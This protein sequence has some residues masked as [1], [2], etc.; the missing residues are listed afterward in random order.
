MHC[1]DHTHLPSLDLRKGEGV[2]MCPIQNSTVLLGSHEL[3]MS[4]MTTFWK[5]P[6][7][8][9]VKINSPL[10]YKHAKALSL[11]SRRS[12]DPKPLGLVKGILKNSRSRESESDSSS[13]D[14][15]K[16]LRGILTK[17]GDSADT[18]KR[19]GKRV[20]FDD[21]LVKLHEIGRRYAAKTSGE[22][23]SGDDV[24]ER[25]TNVDPPRALREING[26]RQVEDDAPMCIHRGSSVQNP[27]VK[28]ATTS[29]LRVG[30]TSCGFPVQSKQ[31]TR[32]FYERD[33]RGS[34]ARSENIKVIEYDRNVP[35]GHPR[36]CRAYTSPML[37]SQKCHRKSAQNVI[38][39]RQEL[40]TPDDRHSNRSIK[41]AGSG[42][43][44]RII[45]Q[46]PSITSDRSDVSNGSHLNRTNFCNDDKTCQIVRWL[47]NVNDTQAKEGRC[48]VLLTMSAHGLRDP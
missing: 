27:F 45:F 16:K 1:T 35:R 23:A 17:R 38:I 9:V 40:S 26:N 42:S 36:L 43:R 31:P 32:L 47:R 14:E 41:S 37:Y 24:D 46:A 22:S 3:K 2:F 6:Y 15:T 29:D 33:F 19:T 28:S 11:S 30:G 21:K 7:N 8:G 44:Q 4:G 39:Y 18:K 5:S 25:S 20:K 48:P 34:S 10:S 13:T 12:D